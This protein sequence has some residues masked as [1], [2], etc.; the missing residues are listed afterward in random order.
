[1]IYSLCTSYFSA[2]LGGK[3]TLYLIF[4]PLEIFH[5]VSFYR[6]RYVRVLL[7]IQGR[8]ASGVSGD[9]ERKIN[10]LRMVGNFESKYSICL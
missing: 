7:N 4:T 9:A 1:M 5:L 8:G 6:Q 10:E 2:L 3:S